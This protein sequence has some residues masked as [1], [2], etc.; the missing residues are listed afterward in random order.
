MG[1]KQWVPFLEV[2]VC[3]HFCQ[4]RAHHNDPELFLDGVLLTVQSQAKF[5]GV[6]FNKKLSFRPHIQYLKEK[7]TKSLNLMKIVAHTDWGADRDTLLKIYNTLIRSKLDYGNIVYGSARKSYLKPLD[8]IHHQ[9]LRLALGAFRT[10]P[11]ESLYVETNEAC[12][13]CLFLHTR[14]KA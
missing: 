6:I 3:V 13:A 12:L 1:G 14:L 7:C 9:G 2:T 4:L 11:S 8:A 10:F 5:L